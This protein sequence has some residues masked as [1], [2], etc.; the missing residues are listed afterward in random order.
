M[1]TLAQDHIER[2]EAWGMNR[3]S[4]S[5]VY[6]PSTLDGIRSVFATAADQ[7]ITVALRGAGCSYG[8]ASMGSGQIVLDLSRM[9]RILN[10]DPEHGVLDAEPGVTIG[11]VWRYCLEDGWWPAVVPGTMF[12]TLGGAAGMNLHGKNNFRAGPI[13]DHILE[14]DLMLPSGDIVTVSRE[15]DPDLFYAAIGGF[16]ML[17]VFTRIKLKLKKVYSGCL[18][19]EAFTT[20][21]VGHMIKELENRMDRADY[22][23]GWID[24]FATGAHLGRGLVHQ[25]N[26]LPEGADLNPAQSLRVCN[27]EIPDTIMGLV[28]KSLLGTLLRPFNTNPGMKLINDAKFIQGATVES[29]QVLLQ[30][31]AQ[32]AFLLDYVPNWKFAY[33]P[34][35]LIQFQSFIP[36]ENAE[37]VFNQQLLYSQKLGV[38]PFLGVFK[39]HRK[40]KFLMSHAVDGNSLALD[41]PITPHNSERLKVLVDQM[42]RL[43]LE[44]GGRF[45]FAK[46]SMLSPK[47]A[48][49][50]LGEEAIGKFTALKRRCDPDNVLQTD[51]SRRLFGGF[52]TS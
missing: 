47:H 26:Y 38:I 5:Q 12:V 19:V 45:Y 29:N 37:Y 33:K 22:L 18:K 15:T 35:A 11:Q 20:K 17:G 42:A 52:E 1:T 32:F 40:D 48:R 51:L 2:V 9:N 25:A 3:S 6:R 8:D 46:D 24:C 49:S 43:V 50:F 21:S 31:H 30:P 27:Q 36:A 13:G 28:P 14:F 10:W 16:G 39:R 23:V 4:L 44:N 41:Y 34:N 7:D